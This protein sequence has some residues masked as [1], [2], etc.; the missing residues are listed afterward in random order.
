MKMMEKKKVRKYNEGQW[1]GIPLR[2]GGYALGI[3]V[4]GSYKTKGGLGYFFGP[5]YARIPDENDTI[6]KKK[7]DA[8]LISWFGDLG[9]INGNWPLIGSSHQF[10][11]DE[12]PIPIFGREISLIPNRGMI[13]EYEDNP[14]GEWRVQKETP[15]DLKEITGLPVD[16]FLGGGV[17]EI[18][19]TKLLENLRSRQV[20]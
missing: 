5:K 10:S 14:K 9:I 7:D 3:I 1:F 16:G 13:I 17:I 8:V 6:E 15:V 12:W 18:K 19:L 4:R 11:R 2:Q 20:S